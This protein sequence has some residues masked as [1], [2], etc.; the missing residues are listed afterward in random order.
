LA[1]HAVEQRIGDHDHVEE[2]ERDQPADDEARH[3][4]SGVDVPEAIAH[5][6]REPTGPPGPFQ[7]R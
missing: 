6:R 5:P 7:Q 2:D 1:A 3:E 4:S